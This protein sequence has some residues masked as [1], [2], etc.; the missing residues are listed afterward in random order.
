MHSDLK[1]LVVS[2][3]KLEKFI[4]GIT[5]NQLS[6][7]PSLTAFC[8]QA[9][10][11]IALAVVYMQDDVCYVLVQHELVAQVEKHLAFYGRFSRVKV[12]VQEGFCV[13]DEQLNLLEMHH[14]EQF[15]SWHEY[16]YEKGWVFLDA[17]TSEKFT[18]QMLAYDRHQFIDWQKGCYLGQEVVARISHRGRNKRHL[19]KTAAPYPV[20]ANVVLGLADHCL[21]VIS[22][23][24]LPNLEAQGIELSQVGA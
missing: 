21:V 13:L 10:K 12:E 19:Y 4:L 17:K 3:K 8:N 20:E 9:G 23:S 5:T 15:T 14:D 18:P 16:L 24:D 1:C 11:V 6:Q 2:G 22:D 7:Q